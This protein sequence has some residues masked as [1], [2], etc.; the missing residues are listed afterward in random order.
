M[1]DVQGVGVISKYGLE[2]YNALIEMNCC[3]FF[4]FDMEA[5]RLSFSNN[6]VIPE[7]SGKVIEHSTFQMSSIIVDRDVPIVIEFL[8]FAGENP[9]EFRLKGFVQN[10]I[11]CQARGTAIRNEQ[12]ETVAFVGYIINIDQQKR[13]REEQ[14]AR[15]RMDSLTGVW[16]QFAV[17]EII[18]GV[19]HTSDSDDCHAFMILDI[20]GF[21]VLNQ[22]LGFLFG[23]VVLNNIAVNLKKRITEGDVIGRVGTDKFVLFLKN[24]ESVSEAYEK[25]ELLLKAVHETYAGENI[26][27]KLSCNVGV[28][29]FPK[30]GTQYIELFSKADIALYQAK[31]NGEEITIY[32]RDGL[33]LPKLA[34][35]QLYYNEYHIKEL[36]SYKKSEANMELVHFAMELLSNT[37][38]VGSAVNMLLDKI[39]RNFLVSNVFVVEQEK[40]KTGISYSWNFKE[41]LGKSTA[42]QKYVE[43]LF[44]LLSKASGMRRSC[45]TDLDMGVRVEDGGTMLLCG[46]YEEDHLKGYVYMERNSGCLR[47]TE[48]EVESFMFITK[49]IS[50]YLLKLRNSERITEKME[51]AKNFD[52]LTGL[53]TVHKFLTDAEIL[54]KAYNTTRFAIVSM[55][56]KN[57][58][59]INDSLGYDA[60]DRLLKEFAQYLRDTSY[61]KQICA[62]S[63][64]DN[65]AVLMPYETAEQLKLRV[66]SI[67]ESFSEQQNRKNVALNIGISA[68]I[69][70]LKDKEKDFMAAIDNANIARKLV[71]NSSV[72]SC[73]FFD[74]N[75]EREIKKEQQIIS[76]MHSALDNEEFQVYLQPKIKLVTGKISGA[77]A[78]VRWMRRDGTMLPPNDFVPLFE[79]NGFIVKL[80]FYIYEQVCKLLQKWKKSGAKIVPISVNVSRVHLYHD[81]FLDKV[82][83]LIRTYQVEP[84]M[85]EFELTESIFL[86]NTVTA[87]TVM[88]ELRKMGFCVS[89]DDFGA[90][91]SSLNLLKDMRTDVLKLDKEFFRAG[92]MKEEE[93]IIVSSIIR[94][95][96]Q[97]NMKVLSEG[98]ETQMQSDFLKTVECDMAQ[99]YLYAKPLP[100]K[101]F[102]LLLKSYEEVLES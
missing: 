52:S 96:K 32:H 15:S 54:V 93:R 90:G 99:G 30:Q 79:K 4:E 84:W 36:G 65:F 73:A 44:E 82:L 10:A 87:I 83:Q 39:G 35:G 61:G 97:L 12:N 62:R 47:W 25:A 58:K 22:K 72:D 3:C 77:E 16:N 26:E 70:M 28:S 38:D 69:Y 56:I 51:M 64:A 66:M 50:F 101:E 89:I 86:N 13:E 76:N 29:F 14:T 78:L 48:Q 21:D 34:E 98:V 63:S 80:D 18:N 60:G 57:F 46:F 37:K 88:K 23:N 49:I 42:S 24:M 11:W 9:I 55:D 43:E 20:A 5:D 45:Y 33:K 81:D 41:G 67:V 92:E 7:L 27:Q 71:K 17:K 53:P 85:I 94:M 95:A 6:M 1:E 8:H 40:K 91:Y 102:E 75:M 59:Y 19:L 2:K 74:D 31:Q 68:G 100:V